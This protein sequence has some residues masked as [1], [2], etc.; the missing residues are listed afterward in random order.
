MPDTVGTGRYVAVVRLATCPFWGMS[1][2]L[3]YDRSK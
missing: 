3:I 2:L 1:V